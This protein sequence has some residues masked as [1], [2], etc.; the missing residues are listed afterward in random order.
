MTREELTKEIQDLARH[1]FEMP[2]L[3][4]TDALSAADV[5]TWTSLSFMNLLTA[6]ENRY[7]F[8]FKMM[9]LLQL[10]NMGA[11]IDVTWSHVGRDA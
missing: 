11:V 7:G 3:V 2:E 1:A 5:D 4:L 8:R 9:E 6:I 10:Q